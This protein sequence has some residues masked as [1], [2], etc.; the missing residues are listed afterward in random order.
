MILSIKSFLAIILV[1]PFDYYQVSSFSL[2]PSSSSFHRQP[3]SLELLGKQQRTTIVTS[4]PSRTP[5]SLSP[6][7]QESN[8]Q[9]KSKFKSLPKKKLF[10]SSSDNGDGGDR[11]SSKKA[12]VS[13]S[14]TISPTSQE[15]NSPTAIIDYTISV[16]T[17]DIGSIIIG[18][19]GLLLALYNRLSTIDFDSNAVSA[20]YAETINIQSRNDLLAV[21]A[22]GAVLLNGVSKLDVTS[23]LAESVSLN[24]VAIDKPSF[25]N[26]EMVESSISITTEK[27]KDLEWA[28]ESILSST[29]AKTA[30]LLTS[31]TTT[32]TVSTL[33]AQPKSKWTPIMLAGIIPNTTSVDKIQLPKGQSTPILDRFLKQ[34][35]AKESYLPTLQALPGKVEF[36]YLPDNAQEAL[37]LPIQVIESNNDTDSSAVKKMYALVVGSDTAKS[38]T[39]RDVAWCQVLANR[40]GNQMLTDS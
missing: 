30:V 29:P 31:S 35:N 25:V 18:S 36:T 21:F 15:L 39:P 2:L 32:T 16:L 11:T 4:P 17:S 5:F 10:A 23:V 7:T 12:S 3:L 14:S 6:F 19:I 13:L 22:A 37:L 34:E 1:T 24:G 40:I 27:K 38:F 8:Q 26:Q 28:M 9:F 20:V 33:E